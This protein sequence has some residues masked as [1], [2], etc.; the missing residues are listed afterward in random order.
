MENTN[1]TCSNRENK[2]I[3]AKYHKLY[4]RNNVILWPTKP[5]RM[6]STF[7]AYN[8]QSLNVIAKNDIF[9]SPEFDCF[10]TNLL[11]FS[12]V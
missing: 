9:S 10:N 2:M 4:L 5:K 8:K 12:L 7:Q 3:W 1:A 6:L 11:R